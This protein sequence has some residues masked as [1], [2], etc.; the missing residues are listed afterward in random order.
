MRGLCSDAAKEGAQNPFDSP[1]TNKDV[2]RASMV[3]GE[4]SSEGWCGTS[5]EWADRK[6]G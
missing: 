1:I 4:R 6:C 3:E 2:K 5:R